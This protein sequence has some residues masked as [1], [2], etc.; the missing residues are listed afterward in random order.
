MMVSALCAYPPPPHD[1]TPA[2]ALGRDLRLLAVHL[3]EQAAHLQSPQEALQQPAIEQENGEPQ[4]CMVQLLIRIVNEVGATCFVAKFGTV[5]TSRY[6]SMQVDASRYKSIQVNMGHPECC[7]FV[8][9]SIVIFCE[10]MTDISAYIPLQLGS[11][12]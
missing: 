2:A 6:K 11:A 8:W 10:H 3:M 5:D 4:G 1:P 12:L 9:C 7:V